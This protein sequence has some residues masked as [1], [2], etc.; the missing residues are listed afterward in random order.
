M[1]FVIAD[2]A[3]SFAPIVYADLKGN[4]KYSIIIKDKLFPNPLRNK[5]AWLNLSLR[6]NAQF[7]MPLKKYY[8]KKGK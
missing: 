5:I 8:Y 6:A 7:T 1:K 4:D 2:V 3:G